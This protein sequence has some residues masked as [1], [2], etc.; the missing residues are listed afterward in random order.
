METSCQSE[1]RDRKQRVVRRYTQQVE[2]QLSTLKELTAAIL[3]YSNNQ[4]GGMRPGITLGILQY[5]YTV[6]VCIHVVYACIM[7]M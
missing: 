3:S 7:F 6:Y 1:T 4:V 2:Q 5:V